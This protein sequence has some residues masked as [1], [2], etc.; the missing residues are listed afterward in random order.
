MVTFANMSVHEVVNNQVF[1]E[2]LICHENFVWAPSFFKHLIHQ[3][4]N[5]LV[6]LFMNVYRCP[7]SGLPEQSGPFQVESS[8]VP[9]FFGRQARN[10]REHIGRGPLINPRTALSQPGGC[11]PAVNNRRYE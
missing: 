1:Q 11:P 9:R 6:E 10:A 2:A 4:T 8:G 5:K 7:R 3:F